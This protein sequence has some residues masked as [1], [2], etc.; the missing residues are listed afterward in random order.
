MY[1][2]GMVSM[3]MGEKDSVCILSTA[4]DLSLTQFILLSSRKIGAKVDDDFGS[5]RFDNGY[6]AANLV[7]AVKG[8]SHLF[9]C[10]V[11]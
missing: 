3:V 6:A 9:P 5:G 1:Q 4:V 7:G 2:A 8:D 11:Y 10:L